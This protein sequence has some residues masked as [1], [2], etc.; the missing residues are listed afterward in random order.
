MKVSDDEL[1]VDLG[2]GT[3]VKVVP[4]MISDVRGKTASGK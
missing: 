2:G 3:K 4:S 1:S